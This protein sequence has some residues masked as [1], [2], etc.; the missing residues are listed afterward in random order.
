M[1]G[2]GKGGAG[3]VVQQNLLIVFAVLCQVLCPGLREPHPVSV[4][5]D[6]KGEKLVFVFHGEGGAAQP[7]Q[8]AQ[9]P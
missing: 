7:Q 2:G 5:Q 6:I 8:G 1:R 4:A 3:V 9:L